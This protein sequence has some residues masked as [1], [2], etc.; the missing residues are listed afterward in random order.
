MDC[1]VV[2]YWLDSYFLSFLIQNVLH[3]LLFS[4]FQKLKSKAIDE[5]QKNDELYNKCLGILL[6]IFLKCKLFCLEYRNNT[7]LS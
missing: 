3:S 5:A 2:G 7:E 1:V 4:R 6:T